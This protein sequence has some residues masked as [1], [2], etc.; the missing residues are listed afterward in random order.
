MRWPL[1]IEKVYTDEWNTLVSNV[2]GDNTKSNLKA[3]DL[4]TDDYLSYQEKNNLRSLEFH[5]NM[6]TRNAVANG[7]HC[8]IS[9]NQSYD[10]WLIS[11]K[12]VRLINSSV[13][14]YNRKF[15]FEI[16]PINKKISDRELTILTGVI[17]VIATIIVGYLS[18]VYG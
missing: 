7:M 2:V 13:K 11:D 14:K 5:P 8:L 12:M 4:V 6:G 9:S 17:G 3:I 15:V 16:G 18:V 10:I 1:K